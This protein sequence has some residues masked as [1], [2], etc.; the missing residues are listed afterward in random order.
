MLTTTSILRNLSRTKSTWQKRG[1][2]KDMQKEQKPQHSNRHMLIC[3][4]FCLLPLLLIFA[5]IKFGISGNTL[6]LLLILLCPLGH[7]LMMK[8][9]HKGHNRDER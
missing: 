4:V 9:G 2:E 5:L 7:V 3:L 1:E 6:F 8:G